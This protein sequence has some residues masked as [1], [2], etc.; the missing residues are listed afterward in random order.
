MGLVVQEGR[1]QHGRA[2]GGRGVFSGSSPSLDV[3]T[4]PKSPG[5]DL[6]RQAMAYGRNMFLLFI[7]PF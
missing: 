2:E 3:P 6:G 4:Q 1:G 5:W 7:S